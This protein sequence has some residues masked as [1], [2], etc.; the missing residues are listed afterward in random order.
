[1]VSLLG[2]VGLGDK[3]SRMLMMPGCQRSS[4][5][6]ECQNPSGL[7]LKSSDLMVVSV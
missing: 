1:M 6:H 2:G 7:V 3:S 4:R 5:E